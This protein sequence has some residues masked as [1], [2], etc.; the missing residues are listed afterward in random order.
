[1]RLADKPNLSNREWKSLVKFQST[2]EEHQLKPSK[3]KAPNERNNFSHC[4][5]EMGCK[6]TKLG[7]TR[8]VQLLGKIKDEN[9]NDLT[10]SNTTPIVGCSKF[11]RLLIRKI[12]VQRLCESGCL[13]YD[14]GDAD[15]IVRIHVIRVRRV[16]FLSLCSNSC[17]DGVAGWEKLT[18]SYST[19]SRIWCGN[20]FISG[21]GHRLQKMVGDLSSLVPRTR[22][23]SFGQNELWNWVKTRYFLVT[24]SRV[25]ATIK[26]STQLAVKAF[27][28]SKLKCSNCGMFVVKF[29]QFHEQPKPSME[30]RKLLMV[31]KIKPSLQKL[32]ATLVTKMSWL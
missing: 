29:I 21:T 12:P 6:V 7:L 4:K 1:M 5:S 19:S 3:S 25:K 30:S 20:S 17:S 11:I 27:L 16:G 9:G 22:M 32:T 18:W 2:T 26:P 31:M 14:V 15:S 28:D 23:S 8:V 13:S 10:K 24:L